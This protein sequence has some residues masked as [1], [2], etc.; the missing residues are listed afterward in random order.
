MINFAWKGPLEVIGSNILLKVANLEALSGCSGH[1][2]RCWKFPRLEVF[3]SCL[4]NLFQSLITQLAL[5]PL[6]SELVLLKLETVGCCSS[7][8]CLWE[9]SASICIPREGL[10]VCPGSL[11]FPNLKEPSFS[12]CSS[13]I[14][15]SIT[16]VMFLLGFSPVHQNFLCIQKAQKLAGC[17]KS[18]F[19]NDD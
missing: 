4:V 18:S 19:D 17:L 14:T 2:F 13:G 1:I 9:E 16:L 3:P 8:A 6:Q 12:S 15:C 10:E 7:I 5:V 11:P